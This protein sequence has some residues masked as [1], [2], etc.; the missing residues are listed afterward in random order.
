MATATGLAEADVPSHLRAFSV[1]DDKV[2][3]YASAVQNADTFVQECR[4]TVFDYVRTGTPSLTHSAADDYAIEL[5]SEVVQGVVELAAREIW[6]ATQQHLHHY[7]P[8]EVADSAWRGAHVFGTTYDA[9]DVVFT[10]ASENEQLWMAERETTDSPTINASTPDWILIG[11]RFVMVWRSNY[12]ES[13]QRHRPGFVTRIGDQV[14]LRV[15]DA[16]TT[17]GTAAN[18]PDHPLAPATNGWLEL[19]GGEGGGGGSGTSRL[20]L[21][22]QTGATNLYTFPEIT[23][24][25][26]VRE[27]FNSP[28]EIPAGGSDD[29][30]FIELETSQ[31]SFHIPLTRRY[32]EELTAVAPVDHSG[33]G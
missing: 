21:T 10:G 7:V 12:S 3:F 23:N 31:G 27:L 14:F 2:T 25:G 19:T 28:L 18:D 22:P 11:G 32:L 8:E 13:G 24:S 9:G 16:Y 5:G 1:L 4:A 15:G 6:L 29:V 30:F 26:Q 17:D 20:A 33:V